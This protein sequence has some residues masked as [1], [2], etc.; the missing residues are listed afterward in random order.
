MWMVSTLVHTLSPWLAARHEYNAIVFSV[1]TSSIL[2]G[3]LVSAASVWPSATWRF[4]FSLQ[5]PPVWSLGPSSHNRFQNNSHVFTFDVFDISKGFYSQP[6]LIKQFFHIIGQSLTISFAYFKKSII[7]YLGYQSNPQ[8]LVTR[9]NITC[10]P[11]NIHGQ[12]N[13]YIN[14]ICQF[15]KKNIFLFCFINQVKQYFL[16]ESSF[17]MEDHSR[18]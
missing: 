9:E 7:T 14:I 10:A 8:K 11:L 5:T 16:K 12:T 17:R 15:W 4:I 3:T 13:Y 6:I 2:H 18:T 1:H